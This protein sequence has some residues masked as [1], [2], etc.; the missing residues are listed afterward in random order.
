MIAWI[1]YSI[2]GLILF[3]I[4][5]LAVLGINR[6]VEAKKINNTE[7]LKNKFRSSKNISSELKKLKGLYENGT[8]T[9]KEFTAAKK[10]LLS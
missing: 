3:F 2:V 9:R 8:I 5:Y 1:I 6:G 10:K 4:L 7:K